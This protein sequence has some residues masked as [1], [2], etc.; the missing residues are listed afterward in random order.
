MELQ[1]A[2][3]GG[4]FRVEWVATLVWN[5]HINLKPDRRLRLATEPQAG[6]REV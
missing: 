1:A 3:R 5:T 2:C 6:R 4:S